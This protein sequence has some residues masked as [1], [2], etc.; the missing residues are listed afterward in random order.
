[1]ELKKIVDRRFGP[2]ERIELGEYVAKCNQWNRV[3]T[4]PLTQIWLPTI[5]AA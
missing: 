2:D 5:L 4:A 3:K 1:M